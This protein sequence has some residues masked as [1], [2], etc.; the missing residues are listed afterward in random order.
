MRKTKTKPQKHFSVIQKYKNNPKLKNLLSD[1]YGKNINVIYEDGTLYFSKNG[2]EEII[3]GKNITYD[4]YLDIQIQSIGKQRGWF[5]LCDDYGGCGNFKGQIEKKTK[6]K[7]CFKKIYVTGSYYDGDCFVG[8]EEHIWM[9][10]KGFE[11]FN[12]NDCVSFYAETY[13]YIKTCNGK[14]LDY[15]LRYPDDIKKIENYELPTDE[16]LMQQA[17]DQI[18]CETCWLRDHCDS[19]FCL[20]K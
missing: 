3:N 18:I 13:K 8:R 2:K 11:K 14:V 19:I 12:I 4:E 10:I 16:E 7:I 20:R 5:Q 15:G 1:F 9:D 17:I 6:D